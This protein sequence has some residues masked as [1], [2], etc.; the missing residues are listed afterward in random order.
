MDHFET[1]GQLAYSGVTKRSDEVRLAF[2]TD[3][4]GSIR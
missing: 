1:A 2:P 3:E 4:A